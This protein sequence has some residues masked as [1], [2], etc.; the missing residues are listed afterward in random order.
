MY[1]SD[2]NSNY[3]ALQVRI[4]KR[5]G[6]SNFTVNYTW[7]HAL[8]D[9]PGNYNS[10]GDVIEWANRHFNYGPTNYDRRQLFVATYTYRLPFLRH[11]RGFVGGAFAGWELSGITRV[12]TGQYLTP[13]GSSSIPGTRRSQYLGQP[14]EL[15]SDVR[16][17]DRWFNTKTFAN[18]PATSLGNS[19]VG[20]IEGP[21]WQV[22]DISLRKVFKIRESWALRFQADAFDLFNHPNFNNPNVTTSNTDFGTITSSQPARQIQLGARLT[23]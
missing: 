16:G 22:W 5:R 8:A 6:N 20:I 3:N 21:G 13:V 7:S 10:T 1:L 14:V 4:T 15:P 2:S 17:V 9:T 18:A 23:F 19:G 11:A 12:Q